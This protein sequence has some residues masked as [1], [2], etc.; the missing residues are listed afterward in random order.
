MAYFKRRACPLRSLRG[1]ARYLPIW[2]TSP[3]VPLLIFQ[4]RREKSHVNTQEARA[5]NESLNPSNGYPPIEEADG[6]SPTLCGNGPRPIVTGAIKSN[7]HV[8]TIIHEKYLAV[9]L[10]V[11]ESGEH[12]RVS[13]FIA[14]QHSQWTLGERYP[15]REARPSHDHPLRYASFRHRLYSWRDHHHWTSGS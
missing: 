9:N 8:C 13:V 10:A 4:E 3:Y 6:H 5:I 11:N 1:A 7:I 15:A 2:L 12:K 14:I